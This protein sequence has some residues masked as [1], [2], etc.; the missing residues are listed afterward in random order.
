MRP[1]DGQ[2]PVNLRRFGA[3]LHEP[4]RDKDRGMDVDEREVAPGRDAVP[5]A[6]HRA[7]PGSRPHFGVGRG[8]S[9]ALAVHVLLVG[10][11]I[12]P[13][14]S[15]DGSRLLVRPA[16]LGFIAICAITAGVAQQQSP[17][18]L[19]LT[20][21]M[22]LRGADR[23]GRRRPPNTPRPGC[24]SAWWRCTAVS[25]SLCGSGT[26]SSVPCRSARASRSGRSWPSSLCGFFRC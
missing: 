3:A 7:G 16:V 1:T 6:G 5:G 26:A 2:S 24:S 11:D 23:H 20:G 14:T 12:S 21:R 8:G 4:P 22:V 9:L 18:T 13:D 25:S 19:K 10:A 15:G 17:F